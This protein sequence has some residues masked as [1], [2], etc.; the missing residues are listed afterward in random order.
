MNR[1]RIE[2][3]DSLYWVEFI[4]KHATSITFLLSLP[5][6]TRRPQT[7]LHLPSLTLVFPLYL[8]PNSLF[9]S[10]AAPF[11]PSLLLSSLY[12]F[13]L[14][15]Q[16]LHKRRCACSLKSLIV[17]NSHFLGF[18][19]CAKT[20]RCF[21]PIRQQFDSS[22]LGLF[23]LSFSFVLLLFCF[24]FQHACLWVSWVFSF[25]FSCF[26]CHPKWVWNVGRKKK[27]KR[28]GE[29]FLKI[30]F[31]IIHELM[32]ESLCFNRQIQHFEVEQ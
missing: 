12:H 10:L 24:S 29:N 32:S 2:S 16:V 31:Q 20:A 18:S 14:R 30:L 27:D 3:L 7:R 26:C 15:I 13:C 19:F 9:S 5:L 25:L 8:P 23:S 28:S 1:S 22:F 6:P 11:Y 4:C 21:R 17:V